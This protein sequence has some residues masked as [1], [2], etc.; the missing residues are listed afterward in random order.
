MG[1]VIGRIH[2]PSTLSAK[3]TIKGAIGGLLIAGLTFVVINRF[4]A[5]TAA[6]LPWQV[7]MG[8]LLGLAAQVGDLGKSVLK[9]IAGVDDSGEFI[10]ALGGVL[11]LVDSYLLASPLFYALT[12]LT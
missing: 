5:L 7:A 9:R 8:L 6:A 4:I 11:D 2:F 10:S 3:K 12:S 1:R